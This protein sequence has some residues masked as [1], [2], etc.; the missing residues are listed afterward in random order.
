MFLST[1]ILFNL[2][3]KLPKV[4]PEIATAKPTAAPPA[5]IALAFTPY[6][7]SSFLYYFSYLFILIQN[8]NNIQKEKGIIHQMS[9]FPTKIIGRIDLSQY[10]VKPSQSGQTKTFSYIYILF[11]Q[12]TGEV[13]SGVYIFVFDPPSPRGGRTKIWPNIMLGKKMIERG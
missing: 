10:T 7:K 1:T 9:I 4:V 11:E 2:N 5:T 12:L 6:V 3:F 13:V 8:S